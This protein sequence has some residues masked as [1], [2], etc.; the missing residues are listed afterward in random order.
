MTIGTSILYGVT[1]TSFISMVCFTTLAAF[2]ATLPLV[3]SHPSAHIVQSR[4][5]R[6]GCGTVTNDEVIADLVA[7][8]PATDADYSELAGFRAQAFRSSSAA[9][10]EYPWGPLKIKTWFHVIAT[11]EKLEDGWIPKEQL[12]AQ[13]A[14]LNDNFGKGPDH[15]SRICEFG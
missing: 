11:S 8:N 6:G 15:V 5:E 14:V 2:A 13:L 4:E 9:A 3:F 12:D 7:L 10:Q 1:W